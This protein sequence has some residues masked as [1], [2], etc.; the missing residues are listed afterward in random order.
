MKT[1][2]SISRIRNIL[3][4]VKEDSFLTDRLIYSLIMKYAKTLMQRDLKLVNLFKNSS[5]FKE[6]PCVVLIDVDR[7][8]ACCIDI[9]TGCT[10]KR[11]KD[12]L[13]TITNLSNGPVIRAVSTLDYSVQVHKTEPSLYA[14]MTKIPSFK[15]NKRK[16]YWFID[17]YLYIP[18]VA[19]EGVRVQ[20]MFEEII[21]K[22]LCGIDEKNICIPEQERDINIPDYLFSEIEN[23]ARQEFLTA[24]QIPSDGADDSQ[25]VMR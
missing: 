2:E 20:A 13:P 6:D 3:K 9:N 12:K 21:N 4:A 11:S 16:Y 15:Y 18:D 8:A 7:V 22:N 19:W 10:F 17:G 1:G 14:N 5:L 24:G 23:L 25:N